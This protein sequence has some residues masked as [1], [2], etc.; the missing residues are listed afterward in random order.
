LTYRKGRLFEYE[1]KKY[2]E[3]RDYFVR[4][5]YASKGLFD[6]LAYKEGAKWGIQCKSLEKNNNRAYIPNK[7]QEALINYNIDPEI[8]Y[9]F[10]QYDK[11]YRMPL[12][13]R[14]NDVFTVVHAY[15]MFPGIGWRR[16]NEKSEWVDIP[17]I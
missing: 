2:L 3:Q 4:R 15:N 13:E 7:E 17:I 8:P 1:V 5:A 16:L 10:V 6:L 9:K 14:L 11:S 12:L